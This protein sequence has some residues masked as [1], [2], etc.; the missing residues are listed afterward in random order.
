MMSEL[1]MNEE[2][3]YILVD[4]NHSATFEG[5]EEYTVGWTG[6]G[7][8]ISP[9]GIYQDYMFPNLDDAMVIKEI[10]EEQFNRTIEIVLLYRW[11]PERTERMKK[12]YKL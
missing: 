11:T 5:W 6:I 7:S 4:K 10:I 9:L 8:P 1:M 3:V 2:G 12:L